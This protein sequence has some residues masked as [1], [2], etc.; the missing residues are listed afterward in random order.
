MKL[1][2]EV[3]RLIILIQMGNL[4]TTV[5]HHLKQLLPESV[6]FTIASFLVED[7]KE[8]KEKEQYNLVCATLY[9]TTMKGMMRFLFTATTQ[10]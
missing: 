8:K 7:P 2:L 3:K 9:R 5:G 4:K 1:H 6:A 10:M